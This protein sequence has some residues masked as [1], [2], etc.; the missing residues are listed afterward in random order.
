M[1][2]NRCQ[3]LPGQ[4][5]LLYDDG[6]G[7]IRPVPSNDVNKYIRQAM[8]LPF[9]AKHFRVWH[10]SVPVFRKWRN[11]GSDAEI[12]Q[13]VAAELGNTAAIARKSY[14]HPQ[15]LQSRAKM[16]GKLARAGKRLAAQ[17]RGLFKFLAQLT[18]GVSS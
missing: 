6:D 15:L 2:G 9:T 12:F 17:E 1:S 18:W 3:D 5:L 10:A 16:P 8:G 7:S 4:N 11:W 13:H 14:I